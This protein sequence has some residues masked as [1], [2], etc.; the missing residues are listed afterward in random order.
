M[1]GYL[2]CAYVFVWLV[3]MIYLFTLGSRQKKVASEI[4]I[5]EERTKKA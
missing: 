1:N 4:E 5:L 2:V 3:H